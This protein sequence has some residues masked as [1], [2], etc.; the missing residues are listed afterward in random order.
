V[1]APLQFLKLEAQ[2]TINAYIDISKAIPLPDRNSDEDSTDV[3]C[4]ELISPQRGNTLTHSEC[5]SKLL[6]VENL[7]NYIKEKKSKT[8]DTFKH[9]YESLSHGLKMKCDIA[10]KPENKLKNRYGNIVAYDHSRVVLHCESDDPHSDYINADYIDAY[11]KPKSFIATQGPTKYTLN[12]IW[13]MTWQHNSHRIV[14]VT[15][16]VEDG[17]HKCEQYWPD[18]GSKM[19]GDIKVDIKDVE[20]LADFTLRTFDIVKG[21]I[22]RTVHQFHFTAWPDHG[23]PSYATSLL[24][25]RKKVR[26]FD[27]PTMGP[28]IVHC[29]AGVGRTGTFIA[30]D[31]L[32]EQARVE[33]QVDIY[34]CVAAMRNMRVNM[35]QTLEQYIFVHD[36]LLEALKCGDTSILCVDFRRRYS[37]LLK[38]NPDTGKQ[39]LQEEFML[40]N[41]MSPA[42]DRRPCRDAVDA[43]N[44]QK[45]RTREVLPVDNLARP[46]LVTYI[47][48]ATDY[49][50]AVF[51]DGYR[52][53][54]AFIVTQMP[55]PSTVMDFWTMV[56]DH[57][58]KAAVMMNELIPHDDT[59]KPYWPNDVGSSLQCGPFTVDLLSLDTSQVDIIVRDFAVTFNKKSNDPH[60]VRQFQ[61]LGWPQENPVP[62]KKASLLRLLGMVEKWQQRSG[63]GIICVHCM[64]GADQSG[65]YCAVSYM[66]ERLKLEQE[67]DVFQSTK[68]V[69]INR[70]Q[71]VPSKIQYQFLYEIAI[72]YMD[73]FDAYANFK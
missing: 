29:S 46:Y 20:Q 66:L 42:I 37:E 2:N 63:N 72:E 58:V 21:H 38:H 62:P 34:G 36:A 18:H 39:R 13:R 24:T 17:R 49:I 60:Y 1:E 41:L 59:C 51:C 44:L 15:N 61:Y 71:L 57:E 4:E 8:T 28:I 7:W 3:E 48:G 45:N 10:R 11:R 43:E 64:N 56:Y 14:M 26:S 27:D 32:L 50:N 30:I 33:G 35:I 53:K 19:Y 70:P 68:H 69:R 22:A 55:L 40:L 47:P 23:V 9:E 52:Q 65:L 12:D 5:K 25:F 6:A 16:L 67:V 54:D 31:Y 73:S